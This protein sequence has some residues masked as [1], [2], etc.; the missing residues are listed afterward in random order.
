M[1]DPFN[2]DPLDIPNL[3][4]A[5]YGPPVS[6]QSGGPS[7]NPA[8]YYNLNAGMGMAPDGPTRTPMAHA[9]R[10]AHGQLGQVLDAGMAAY[11]G[12]AGPAVTRMNTAARGA[13]M[14]PHQAGMIGNAKR[15]A[16][17]A[18]GSKFGQIALKA[19]PALGVA[20]AAIG[21]GDII[22]GDDS[23]GNKAMD[24][25]AMGVGGAIG[26]FLG[27]GVFSPI[28]AAVGAGIGKSVSDA[29]QFIVGGGKSEKERMIEQLL[30]QRGG[31]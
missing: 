15:L 27:G 25:A 2:L 6:V 1:Y 30:A 16:G 22:F 14:G 28:T 12:F 19:A 23:L 9:Y 29:T 13:L 26:G 17:T 8:N 31:M 4:G 20:G 3:N 7:F 24:T 11:D 5:S 18:L 10:K 21:A